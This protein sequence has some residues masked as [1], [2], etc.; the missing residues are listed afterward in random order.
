MERIKNIKKVAG[1]NAYVT[2]DGISGILYDTEVFKLVGN[3]LFLNNGGWIT[4]STAKCIN[5]LLDYSG[6]HYRVYRKKGY[7]FLMSLNDAKIQ[8][9]FTY[10]KL[11][12]IL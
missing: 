8:L 7:M 3:R 6:L 9:P 12:V 10:N 4:M 5:L 2:N 1:F 11:E